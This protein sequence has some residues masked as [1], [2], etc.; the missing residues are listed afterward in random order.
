MATYLLA[1][2]VLAIANRPCSLAM[3]HAEEVFGTIASTE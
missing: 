1:R 2:A 3:R